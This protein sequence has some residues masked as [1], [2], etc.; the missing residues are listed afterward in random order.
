MQSNESRTI[1]QG[2]GISAA[3][4]LSIVCETTGADGQH[5]K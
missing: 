2:I 5:T 3:G 4:L 1:K